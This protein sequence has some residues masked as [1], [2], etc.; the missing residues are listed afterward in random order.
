M[1]VTSDNP[2][3]ED[4]LA[5]AR[6]DRERLS[7]PR[8]SSTG[9]RRSAARSTQARRATPSSSPA[10]ATRRIRSSATKRARSTIATKCASR[11]PSA[12][13]RSSDEAAAARR[14][15]RAAT[16]ARSSRGALPATL[17]VQTDTRAIERGRDVSRVARRALRR[18]RATSRRRSRAARPARSSTT[19]RRYRPALP[20]LVVPI[21]C[22]RISTSARLAR[23]ADARHG[24]RHHR[25]HRQD[26]DEAV[27]AR[28][29][30]AAPASPATA[31]PENENNE[32]G[33]AK[34]L[35]GLDDGDERVAIV[36][37]GARK[38]RD[39]DVL[40]AAARPDVGVLTNI[41]EAHLEIMG[42]PRAH[43]RDEVGRCRPARRAPCSISPMRSSRARAP[44]LPRRPVWFGIDA[45]RPPH[46]ERAVV[47][48]RRRTRAD[49]RRR[50]RPRTHRFEIALSRRS[51]PA[52]SGRGVRR[53]AA[54]RRASA[55]R[56]G[57]ARRGGRAVRAAARALRGDRAGRRR[58]GHVRCVQCVA[59]GHARNARDVRPR[60]SRAAHRRARQHGRTRRR[61]AGDAREDRRDRREARRRSCSPAG[62]SPPTPRAA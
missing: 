22:R 56:R 1:I 62:G 15:R 37:M 46:G 39:L 45:E 25:Q 9:A 11:S 34:F 19:R 41:G 52:Q 18:P 8:S 32:I 38:Y 23:D 14:D 29:C 5:I 4:P 6:A 24:R 7:T 16:R 17:L 43:R 48:G 59:V 21:R 44:S 28:R 10:R 30:C 42:S 53:R 49:R 2:R 35:C 31:T 54:V 3:S 58:A 20:A 55:R 33:V 27:F 12:P 40:V 36:E 13:R 60:G 26:D 51:Q 61:C 50:R 57:R 47:I